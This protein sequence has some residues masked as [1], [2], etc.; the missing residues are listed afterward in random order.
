MLV[1]LKGTY[2]T[3]P[4]SEAVA[5]VLLQVAVQ[6]ED[7]HTVLRVR[8]TERFQEQVDVTDE[9]SV[10]LA[11]VLEILDKEI[12]LITVSRVNDGGTHLAED[13]TPM[14]NRLIRYETFIRVGRSHP[15][16][17]GLVGH[18]VLE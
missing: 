17:H 1:G 9:V 2:Q 4:C 7:D 18:Q 3:V 13:T 15:F 14:C 6:D 11:H 5:Q 16:H 12:P 8:L 10:V